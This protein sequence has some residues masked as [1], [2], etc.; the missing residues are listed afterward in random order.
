MN[1][2]L[3]VCWFHTTNKFLLVDDVE[4]ELC[5]CLTPAGVFFLLSSYVGVSLMSLPTLRLRDN[6]EI[7]HNMHIR[8]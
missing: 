2:T 7:Q 3:P 6:P 8:S 4:V 1:K 5:T